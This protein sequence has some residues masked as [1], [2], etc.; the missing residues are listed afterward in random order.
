MQIDDIL[1]SKCAMQQYDRCRMLIWLRRW[2]FVNRSGQLVDFCRRHG[3]AICH[4]RQVVNKTVI[5]ILFDRNS[6]VNQQNH[7]IVAYSI[8]ET[9]MSIIFVAFYLNLKWH[10]FTLRCLPRYDVT[11]WLRPYVYTW[12]HVYIFTLLV[13]CNRIGLETG[14]S[15]VDIIHV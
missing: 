5:S 1:V 13:L 4:T 7:N 14:C 6:C 9:C 2:Y 12:Q 3:R 11:I 10:G 8:L 15:I